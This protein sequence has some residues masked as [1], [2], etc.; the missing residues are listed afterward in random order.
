MKKDRG[1]GWGGGGGRGPLFGEPAGRKPDSG[2]RGLVFGAIPFPFVPRPSRTSS[3]VPARATGRPD[4]R[5]D[6]RPLSGS[7]VTVLLRG[8]AAAIPLPAPPRGRVPAAVREEGFLLRFV[9]S[10]GRAEERIASKERDRGGDGA[11]RPQRLPPPL[12]RRAIG[13]SA[14]VRWVYDRAGPDRCRRER[15]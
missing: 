2:P 11:T 3:K 14:S 13:R 9:K 7:A 10:I 6:Y 15:G 4:A 5:F 8:C 1:L 12:S